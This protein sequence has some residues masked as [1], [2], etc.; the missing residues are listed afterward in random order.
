M[1]INM[2]LFMYRKDS[3]GLTFNPVHGNNRSL[4]QDSSGTRV[5]YPL[6]KTQRSEYEI[7]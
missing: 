4:F 3:Q 1:M 7:T 5:S 6:R 2:I